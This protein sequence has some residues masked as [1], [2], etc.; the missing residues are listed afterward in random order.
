MGLEDGTGHGVFNAR[1]WRTSGAAIVL[2]RTE[3]LAGR[4]RLPAA[5]PTTHG[6]LYLGGTTS[7]YF[8]NQPCNRQGRDLVVL[9]V[10]GIP[11]NGVEQSEEFLFRV[12]P[13]DALERLATDSVEYF[14]R[15]SAPLIG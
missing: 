4:E 10:T 2:V 14:G 1:I 12:L 9:R 8:V 6:N 7:R 15:E 11:E 5:E 13:N 3:V